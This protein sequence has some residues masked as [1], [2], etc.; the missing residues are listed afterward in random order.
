M[1]AYFKV[2]TAVNGEEGPPFALHHL[3]LSFIGSFVECKSL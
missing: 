3:V 1:L 2:N